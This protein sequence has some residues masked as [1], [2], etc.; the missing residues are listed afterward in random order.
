MRRICFF[1]HYDRDGLVAPHVIHYVRA[2]AAAE[3]QVHF[4]ST[5]P[6]L[7]EEARGALKATCSTVTVRENR[8][9]DFGSWRYGLGVLDGSADEVLLTNDSVFGPYADLTALVSQMR[10]M[11]CDV[12]GLTD[13]Y[14]LLHHL[15][16][17]FLLF[18]SAHAVNVLLPALLE[19]PFEGLTKP[20]IITMGE[21]GL[22][23]VVL[24]YRGTLAAMFPYERYDDGRHLRPTNPTHRRWRPLMRDGFPFIKVELLRDNPLGLQISDWNVY[25][26]PEVAEEIR[27]YLE[28]FPRSTYAIG[29]RGIR[30]RLGSLFLSYGPL[31]R[32][33]RRFQGGLISE[34]VWRS[35]T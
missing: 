12:V 23:R 24:N 30:D 14:E 18:R 2:L 6:R 35:G 3:Y 27:D 22:T 16:S 8:G 31:R 13:S 7:P 19:P 4:I 17:Y 29:G 32:A 5:A 21:L 15:Q 1:S 28:R 25:V 26:S 10:A 34:R 9:M 20:Q 33:V 11:D